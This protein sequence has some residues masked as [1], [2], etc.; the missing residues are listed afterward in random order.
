MWC[1]KDS[2]P[3][4]RALIGTPGAGPARPPKWWYTRLVTHRAGVRRGLLLGTLVASLA[5]GSSASSGVRVERPIPEGGTLRVNVTGTDLASLDPALNYDTDGAQLLYATCA[6]LLN[7]PDRRAPHGSTLTPELAAAMP[8]VS[9]DGRVYR[10]RI[11]SGFTFSN[12]RPV[13]AADMAYTIKRDLDSRMHSPAGAF[14]RDVASYSAHGDTLTFHLKQPRPDFLARLAMSFFCVVPT[15]T[16]IAPHGIDTIPSAGPY[17]VA[18]RT[19]AVSV[20]LKRNRYYTGPRPHHLDEIDFSVFRDQRASVQDIERGLA[21]YDVHG[22]QPKQLRAVALRYGVNGSRLLAHPVTETDYIALN[23]QRPA[24]RDASVRR[25]VAYAIDREALLHA[26][27]FLAG[28][29]TDQLL[30]PSLPGFRNTKIYPLRADLR[31]ARRLMHGRRLRAVLYISDAPRDLSVALVLTR[32]LQRIGIQVEIRRFFS[33]DFA[34]RIHR[35][36][37]PFDM[38]LQGV[39]ADYLDPYDFVNVLLSGR[40][41]VPVGNQNVA[42]FSDSTFDR[43]MDAAARLGGS[44]RYAAY[45]RLEVDIL[46][47]AAPI[48]PYANEYRIEFVSRRLGCVV[49]A[50]GAGGLDYTAACVKQ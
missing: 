1:E 9:R 30:P 7:Y 16:P 8:T 36:D 18:A 34:R 29:V 26:T 25:A 10:F 31:T 42:H 43:K 27:G 23:T 17:Y 19:P 13:Q 33:A 47:D 46:R 45:S 24:F 22:V 48:V 39:V 50:P 37:E 4:A 6:K 11:S 28:K 3:A 20:T 21:D 49:I 44:A 38:A 15:G 32:Q 12:G 2:K 5:L 41:L 40:N 14:L 35:R